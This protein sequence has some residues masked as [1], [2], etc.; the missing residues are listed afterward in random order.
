MGQRKAGTTGEGRAY[1]HRALESKKNRSAKVFL[2]IRSQVIII[3]IGS[4]F[5]T[6][7]QHLS[8]MI[9]FLKATLSIFFLKKLKEQLSSKEYKKYPCG[10]RANRE[11]TTHSS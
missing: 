4:L 5:V 1:T 2:S 3:K 7:L 9:I 11:N 8:H 6:L 10:C